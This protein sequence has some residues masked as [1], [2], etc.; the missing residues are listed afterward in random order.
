MSAKVTILSSGIKVI[1]NGKRIS[2]EDTIKFNPIF[3][4]PISVNVS[5]GFVPKKRISFNE[6]ASR[7]F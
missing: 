1:D 4:A 5:S 2:V 6:W 7:V 3:S